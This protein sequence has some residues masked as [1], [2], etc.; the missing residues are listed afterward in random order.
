MVLRGRSTKRLYPGV[1]SL[2]FTEGFSTSISWVLE[3]H[4]NQGDWHPIGG[5]GRRSSYG[6]IL[7]DRTLLL[8]LLLLLTAYRC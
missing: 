8:L 5:A 7:Y 3:H 6:P 4:N 2:L 1:S